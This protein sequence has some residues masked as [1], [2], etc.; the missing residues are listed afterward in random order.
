MKTRIET[1]NG[2]NIRFVEYN[3]EWWAVLKDICNALGLKTFKVS[4]RL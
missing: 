4:Q 2:Y 3:G 1:W